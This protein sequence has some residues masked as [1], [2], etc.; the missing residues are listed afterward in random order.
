MARI[1]VQIT[2]PSNNR[3]TVS[4][5]ISALSSVQL[6]LN[7]LVDVDTS[8]G[9]DGY[10]LTQQADGSFAMEAIVTTLSGLS[11]TNISSP[12]NGNSLVYDG[13]SQK[14]IPQTITFTPPPTPGI[15]GLADTNITNLQDDQIIRYDSNSGK[16]LNEDLEALPAGGT[17]GQ[18]LV[19]ATNTDYDV[20]WADISIDVQYHNRYQSTA[21]SLRA[22][23]TA[24]TELYYAAQADG[25]G[26]AE[27][28]SSD[29][30]TTGYDIQ[31]KLY[32]SE[33][34]FA[35]PDTGTWI[36]FAAIADNTT[37][38]NAKAA[39]LAYLKDRTGGTV[40]I[41][42]KQTWEEV[43]QAPAFTGL[44][45][46]SYGSGAAAA[47]STR[48][49]NG[50]V[51]ECMV[52]RRA[53]DSTTTTIGF[54]ANGN[55]DEAAINTF[56]SGTTCTVQTWIDQS[57]NGNNATQATPANQPTIY[58]GGAIV[59]ENGRVAV[60]FSNNHLA[61]S[62]V[63]LGSDFTAFALC[64]PDISYNNLNRTIVDTGSG[65]SGP[66]LRFSN[67]DVYRIYNDT[68]IDDGSV[69]VGQNLAYANVASSSELAINGATADTGTFASAV[70]GDVVK[71]G[72]KINN[73]LPFYGEFQEL[74]LY[75]SDKSSVR[76]SIESNVG[77]YFTQNTP[78]LDTYS[79]AAAAYSLR[80]LS[81]SYS[82]SAIRVRRASDNAESDI[83]FNVFGELDTVS[84]ASFCSGTDGFVKT[85]Y[86][87]ASTNDATQTTTGSQ[88]KIYDGA[89]AAVVTENGKPS[90]S[91]NGTQFFPVTVSLTASQS[92]IMVT[93]PS[94]VIS[95]Y[96][97]GDGNK[98]AI[99]TAYSGTKIE[100]FNAPRFTL[101]T[102]P[103][104]LGLIEAFF[105]ATTYAGFYNGTAEG[106]GT[107]TNIA[108]NLNAIGAGSAVGLNAYSG[109]MSEF[110]L[111]ST[112]QSSNR[113]NI[114][115]NVNTFYSIY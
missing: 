46:E 113:A 59:K 42:L 19:K 106:S 91:F 10:V 108:T 43:Q 56:C 74:I 102:T 105:D 61:T 82:G 48:R 60:L 92:Q 21:A 85:W 14:W 54:D 13:P 103:S 12:N 94:S 29:T 2:T 101:S 88:P 71:I 33:A 72:A 115:S 32:Y 73:S 110:I 31:R 49:L 40:P 68:F 66:F 28:A 39:L 89:T 26:F 11:D 22:G 38:A 90:V 18:A 114:E 112:D 52:I 44:L 87:Q 64:S 37:F 100:M 70:N 67:V 8:G 25:D 76:T 77:D 6:Y 9:Q 111:Y 4:P 3:I 51:S 34:A 17:T 93:T 96:I 27:S 50:N 83:G 62:A 58:T 104:G 65:G 109:K 16:W 35:D 36:Q 84:L 80:K 81:S 15:S 55:I 53:S 98:H 63:S 79:G 41:S 1:T 5:G 30:P 57:G 7:E 86:D 24:T 75:P 20:Q 99:I 97:T 69:Q 95:K 107:Y 78:L 23:A 45:N 47:Y